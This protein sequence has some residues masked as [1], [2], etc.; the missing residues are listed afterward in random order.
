VVLPHFFMSR[1]ICFC[2]SDAAV[3]CAGHKVHKAKSA[4]RAL[5]AMVLHRVILSHLWRTIQPFKTLGLSLAFRM[6]LA[7]WK[8][9]ITNHQPLFTNH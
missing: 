8:T 5:L 2:N 6:T 9:L 1:T 3:A 7:R 4:T